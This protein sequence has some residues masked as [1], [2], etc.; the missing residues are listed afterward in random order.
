[1]QASSP[2]IK[3]TAHSTSDSSRPPPTLPFTDAFSGS[4]G[5]T[6]SRDWTE[7]QGLLNQTG[8][9]GLQATAPSVTSIATVNTA[10]ADSSTEIDINT[11]LIGTHYEGLVARFN[12][13]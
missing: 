6:L 10:L 1:M 11:P 13:A 7:R 5:A 2:V 4:P 8:A 9:G 12:A 3:P